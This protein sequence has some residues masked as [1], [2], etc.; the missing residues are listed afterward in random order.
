MDIVF[1]ASV[2]THM[3]PE[4][5][6]NYFH[7]AA[8]VVK[9]MGHC[10]FSFFLFDYYRPDQLRPHGFS[11]PDFNFDHTYGEYGDNFA[12]AFPNDPERMTAYSLNLIQQ[13]SAESGLEYALDPVPGIWSGSFKVSIGAQDF[14]IL[15]KQETRV[16]G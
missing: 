13:M 6:A 8:R 11:R 9:P 14:I 1:A 16:K 12:I 4:G 15:R 5:V 10:I 2:F 7:E 3:L